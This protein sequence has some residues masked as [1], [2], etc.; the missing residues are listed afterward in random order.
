MDIILILITGAI[1]ILATIKLY[2]YIKYELPLKRKRQFF[3]QIFTNIKFKSVDEHIPYYLS[4]KRVSPYTQCYSF[5][6]FIPLKVWQAK[7]DI[8]EMQ[9]NKKIIDIKQSEDDN[10]T[11]NVY[12]ET[13][14]LPKKITWNDKYIFRGAAFTLGVDHYGRVGVCLE[15]T[16]HG[17]IA[18]ET[19][20]G[21][22]NILKC[23][24]HQALMK[25]Y[26][27]ILIDFKRGVSFSDF[28]NEV[29][30]YY[31]YKA[32]IEVLKDL[33][34][35]T[36]S[37]LDKF[38]ESNVD[39][40]RDYNLANENSFNR[41][42]IFIDELAELLK[43]RDK[44][45]SNILYESIETLT[46]LSRAVGI[47]LIIGVQRPDST[48][49]TGQIK[50]NVSFRICG[51]FVDKE[52]SRIMLGTDRASALP[53]IKG[54]FILKDDDVVEAQSF[55]FNRAVL[56]PVEAKESLRHIK[57]TPALENE[58]KPNKHPSKEEP[59]QTGK[60]IEFDFSEFKK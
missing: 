20:S 9:L 3:D 33:V 24:I 12:I 42:I 37:R 49:I 30:V 54:R 11:I 52:P 51:H 35:E 43:T 15:T 17:F 28:S 44:E 60:S 38:R 32:V 26:D 41:K 25:K 21:K 22:S 19:G 2:K 27:V 40:L 13:K 36:A 55:L 47:H 53:N 18:G 7:R 46:R 6:T 1:L 5:H 4:E 14:P 31:E 56:S 23:F 45:I 48:I 16:P 50:S 59:R 8:L 58:I 39:N 29:S 57:E 10:R 34:N